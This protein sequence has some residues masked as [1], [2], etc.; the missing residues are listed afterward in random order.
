VHKFNFK[1]IFTCVKADSQTERSKNHQDKRKPVGMQELQLKLPQEYQNCAKQ[2]GGYRRQ[3][4][5]EMQKIYGFKEH[6]SIH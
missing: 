1:K 5:N 3:Q 4:K 6:G 2:K